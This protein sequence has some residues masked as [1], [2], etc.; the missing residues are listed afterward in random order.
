MKRN[1]K[2]PLLVASATAIAAAALAPATSFAWSIDT[3][4]SALSA[5]SAG[6]TLL[7][8]I[9]TTAQGAR[10]SFSVT[11]TSG[12]TV[13]AKIRFRE[14][15]HSM[16]VLDF[17]VVMSPFDK[18]DFYVTQGSETPRMVWSD[19]S[20]V[21]G[22][23]A[24]GMQD[25]VPAAQNEFVETNDQMSAG[26]LEVLGMADLN[27]VF[28]DA[29]GAKAT[30]TAGTGLFSL[31]GA[32]E[33]DADGEPANCG[34]VVRALANQANVASIITALNGATPAA[35]D[36]DNVLVGRYVI[37]DADG[38][39]EAGSDAYAIRD[40][41]LGLYAQTGRTCT[42]NCDANLTGV[43]LPTD[44]STP[45]YAWSEAE[46]SHPHLGEMANFQG[47]QTALT[48]TD[49]GGDW[50]NN[51]D[52][53]VGVDWV[54]SFPSKYTYLD[55]VDASACGGTGTS[56]VWCL[57]K[58]TPTPIDGKAG[59]W[60]SA[61]TTNLCLQDNNLDVWDTE[62]KVTEEGVSVSPGFQTQYDICNELNV[63]TVYG[64]GQ[65]PRPS[66]IQ[67]TARRT[68]IQF[69]GLDDAVRGWAALDLSWPVIN[70]GGAM[71]GIVFT[72][73]ATVDPAFAN[74]S[75]T[76]LQKRQ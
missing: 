37:T 57:L 27:G 67:T 60:T 35:G 75:I 8:P 47:F 14:Q 43:L 71:S 17:I 70:Q 44:Q 6:D 39:I 51:P 18:F 42:D 34:L 36:V 20:C 12:Q 66:V 48:A 72:Q 25:F 63:L 26:H 23:A 59:A 69:T 45:T 21:V 4:A 7:F 32:A 11:N 61:N 1:P 64:L 74:G 2:L 16:D 52:N 73:R 46:W 49:V 19:N 10:T 40:T 38:G 54:V 30:M 9:Y 76:E 29:D 24:G 50:S 41:N 65:E 3:A 22:P 15:E 33:H 28:V 13:A 68:T 62:E 56:K 53:N 31:A 5:D 55:Y 58:D